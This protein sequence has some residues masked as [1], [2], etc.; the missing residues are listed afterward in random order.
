M[1][2]KDEWDYVSTHYSKISLNK[3][4]KEHEPWRL[5]Q[6]EQ[7]IIKEPTKTHTEQELYDMTKKEQI[8]ILKRHGITVVP[9]YEKGRVDKI[10]E[11][12]IEGG[13]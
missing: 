9:K 12:M 6:E 7:E 5:C 4:I 3:W 1:A 13:D 8:D 11:I 10:L 2:D